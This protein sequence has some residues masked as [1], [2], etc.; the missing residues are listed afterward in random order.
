MKKFDSVT[1]ML[2]RDGMS[3]V[4]SREIF[5]LLF[6]KEYPDFEHYIGDDA[7]IVKNEKF[8]KAVMRISRGMPLSDSERRAALRLLKPTDK[9][10]H[11]EVDLFDDNRQEEENQSSSQLLRRKLE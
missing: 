10:P 5:D 3:F 2:Q 8:E 11:A 7:L 6:L 1:V 4:E 9:I